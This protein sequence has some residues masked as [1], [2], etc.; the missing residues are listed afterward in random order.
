MIS[1]LESFETVITAFLR[2]F[3]FC[4]L[5]PYLEGITIVF[6]EIGFTQYTCSKPLA[7]STLFTFIG[8]K[9][10]YL[11]SVSIAPKAF[12]HCKSHLRI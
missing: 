5:E 6:T 9:N 3:L 11:P 8:T 4:L 7:I 1:I 12:S 2:D 10:V